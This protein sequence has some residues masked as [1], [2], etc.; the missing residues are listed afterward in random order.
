MWAVFVAGRL[1]TCIC[2][3][4]F[5]F[6]IFKLHLTY[7]H[8]EEE[9]IFSKL[10]I[11]KIGL[12][13]NWFSLN[14]LDNRSQI[15]GSMSHLMTHYNNIDCWAPLWGFDSVG[16]TWHQEGPHFKNHWNR[17]LWYVA[18]ERNEVCQWGRAGKRK[19]GWE[20]GV[21]LSMSYWQDW[22]CHTF[23]DISETA[24]SRA[25]L[26]REPKYDHRREWLQ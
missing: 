15:Q 21:L 19:R 25:S 26:V 5:R 10:A 17:V 2:L 14:N 22:E 16:L 1:N 6:L 7:C 24:G 18:D 3:I 20:T 23:H 11:W 13:A 9:L 12:G 4:S 8:S